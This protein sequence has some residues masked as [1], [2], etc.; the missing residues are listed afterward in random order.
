MLGA[1]FFWLP[2]S[3]PMAVRDRAT[4][5]QVPEGGAL[6]IY[7]SSLGRDALWPGEVIDVLSGCG[8]A[9][10][11]LVNLSRAGADSAEGRAVVARDTTG[12][13]AVAI[14]EYVINDADI[15][16]G[17]NRKTTR[18]NLTEMV[19]VLKARTPDAAV[20]LMATNPVAGLQRLK[21]PRLMS[22]YDLLLEVA[23]AEDVGFFDGAAHWRT[24][25]PDHAALTDGLHPD[26]AAEAVIYVKPF[27]RLIARSLGQPCPD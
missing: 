2:A 7:G 21:R 14:L 24:A 16:D 26:P 20:F 10:L 23:E 1:A 27:A 6:V 13:I 3:A 5:G 17:L 12:P 19:E 25:A 11:Y 8:M 22:Y 9:P 15:L 18:A 4:T